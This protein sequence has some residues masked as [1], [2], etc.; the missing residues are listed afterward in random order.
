MRDKQFLMNLTKDIFGNLV[1]LGLDVPQDQLPL[2]FI[3]LCFLNKQM[4]KQWKSDPPFCLY[5]YYSKSTGQSVNG[6]PV[7]VSCS[8]LSKQD[9][10]FV[11]IALNKLHQS[12]DQVVSTLLQ[13]WSIFYRKVWLPLNKTVCCIILLC[14]VTIALTLAFVAISVMLLLF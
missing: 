8:W 13:D 12:Q 14:F 9:W 4:L 11:K 3:P 10:S 7:F 5:E 6:F 1:F 2:V